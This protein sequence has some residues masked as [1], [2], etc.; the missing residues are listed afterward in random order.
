MSFN[1]TVETINQVPLLHGLRDFLGFKVFEYGYF[2]LDVYLL[3]Y[4]LIGFILRL[5]IK[6]PVY[7]FLIVVVFKILKYIILVQFGFVE[8]EGIFNSILDVVLMIT[9]W[10]LM[11]IG[12]KNNG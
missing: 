10:L 5:I 4:L 1:Q 2:F 3:M 8:N 6:N 7:L 11:D 9:G 12:L